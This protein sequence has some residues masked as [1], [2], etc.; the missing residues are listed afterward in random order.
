VLLQIQSVQFLKEGKLRTVI[1]FSKPNL[2]VSKRVSSFPIGWSYCWKMECHP[3]LFLKSG[4]V[5]VWWKEF[6]LTVDYHQSKIESDAQKWCTIVLKK[7]LLL[8]IMKWL[9]EKICNS[10]ILPTQIRLNLTRLREI[11][12]KCVIV[13]WSMLSMETFDFVSLNCDPHWLF[14]W[15]ALFLTIEIY[16]IKHVDL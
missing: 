16:R 2:L 6:I 11:T 4:T 5:P 1:G 7:R 3:F 8:T 14:Q 12:I 10:S 9:L 13:I 15:I